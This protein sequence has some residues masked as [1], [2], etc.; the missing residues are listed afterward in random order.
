V[1][2]RSYSRSACAYQRRWAARAR[3]IRITANRVACT[4]R[5]RAHT[6]QKLSLRRICPTHQRREHTVVESD[7]ATAN[8]TFLSWSKMLR[9]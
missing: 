3:V 5:I 1:K 6:K 2:Q 7:R 8:G 9:R 4:S